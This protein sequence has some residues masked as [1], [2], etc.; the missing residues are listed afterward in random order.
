MKKLIPVLLLSSVFF[1]A[2]SS[3]PSTNTTTPSVNTS[4]ETKTQ[5]PI[6][7]IMA[8]FI[9]E[10]NITVPANLTAEEY[11]KQSYYNKFQTYKKSNTAQ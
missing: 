6:D 1:V 5:A 4:S 10:N 7:P 8:K 11:I 2:C 9:Q 3:S